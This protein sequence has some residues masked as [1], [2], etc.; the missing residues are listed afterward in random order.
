MRE[1]V[2]ARESVCVRERESAR[3]PER[4]CARAKEGRR[5]REGKCVRGRWFDFYDVLSGKST[6]AESRKNQYVAECCSVLQCVFI[7]CR[8]ILRKS[9]VAES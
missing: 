8:D 4:A 2:C 6:A 9:P 1:S 5:E 3:A 7:M